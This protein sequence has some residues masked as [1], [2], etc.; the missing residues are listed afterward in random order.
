VRS[1]RATL[2]EKEKVKRENGD[3]RLASGDGGSAIRAVWPAIREPSRLLGRLQL[4]E[5]GPGGG[6]DYAILGADS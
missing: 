6:E 1:F 5:T 2:T 3:W 4:R